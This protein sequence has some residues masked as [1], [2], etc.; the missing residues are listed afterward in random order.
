MA[1][2]GR[3]A[4]LALSG[5]LW[6]ALSLCYYLRPDSCAAVTVF[7]PWAWPPLG[8]LLAGIGWSVG[9]KRSVW[10]LVFLWAAYLLAFTDE[11]HG[12]IHARHRQSASQASR[13]GEQT[14]RV[15]C[16]NCAG[17]R[18][19]AAEEVAAYEPDVVLLQE[20]PGPKDVEQL[21]RSLFQEH[22]STL[23]QGDVAVIARGRVSPASSARR[24]PLY[25][26]HARVRLTS[27]IEAEVVNLHLFV[28]PLRTD[29]WNTRS[30]REQTAHRRT[31]RRQLKA[32]ADSIKAVP[33]TVP[34]IVGGD[35]NAPAGDAIFRLLQPRLHDTFKKGGVGWGGTLL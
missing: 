23:C 4:V 25:F 20:L 19:V 11:V 6:V 18:K 27:G 26:L 17:G 7:P 10:V 1:R 28:P 29:I 31:Q 33:R 14:L 15:V 21:A 22:G 2:R 12:L 30:W 5:A 32:I 9:T 16:L 8:L 13:L 34:L 24:L 3:A 35:F